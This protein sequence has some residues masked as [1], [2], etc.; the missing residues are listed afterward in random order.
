MIFIVLYYKRRIMWRIRQRAGKQRIARAARDALAVKK[1]NSDIYDIHVTGSAATSTNGDRLG[2]G[3]E[4]AWV[5]GMADDDSMLGSEEEMA[6]P[7][8]GRSAASSIRRHISM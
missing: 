2:A 4:S 5:E 1:K 6:Q 8:T 3:H 7:Y